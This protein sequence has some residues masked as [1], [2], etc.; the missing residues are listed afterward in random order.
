MS[1]HHHNHGGLDGVTRDAESG[2]WDEGW[3]VSRVANGNVRL[4]LQL[5]DG[6]EVRLV[7]AENEARKL[8]EALRNV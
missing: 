4:L 2:E 5:R 1:E 3:A 8:S 6:A 7:L